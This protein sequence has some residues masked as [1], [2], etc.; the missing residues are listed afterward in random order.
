MGDDL[1][2]ATLLLLLLA[3][4]AAAGCD[5]GNAP[6]HRDPDRSGPAAVERPKDV[7]RQA[8]E[9]T[10][11]P[12]APTAGPESP[13]AATDASAA[14][15]SASAAVADTTGAAS[16]E[17]VAT[18]R[19]DAQG[20][21]AYG[22]WLQSAGRHVA[23]QPSSV[24]AVVVAKGDYKCNEKYPFKLKLDPPAAGVSYPETTVRGIRYGKQ[25]SVLTVPF[26]A[27]EPGQVTIAGTFYVSVC[28]AT[29]CKM[30]KQPLSV[31][32]DVA[33]AS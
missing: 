5:R 12:T 19:G 32:V 26:T 25:R 9:A 15:A 27:A 31:T 1:R 20:T 13:S 24:Q 23:G 7:A 2:S 18:T 6:L 33:P 17:P 21:D 28:N 4:A 29:T 3:S 14:N 11:E 22:A 8:A 10:T 30:G 16:A